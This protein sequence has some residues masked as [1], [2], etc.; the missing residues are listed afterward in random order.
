MSFSCR[1]SML[2]FA[3]FCTLPVEQ[4]KLAPPDSS[5]SATIDDLRK[6]LRAEDPKVR[7]QAAQKLAEFGP[8]AAAAVPDFFELIS[9]KFD[10]KYEEATIQTVLA[11]G[12]VGP[13]AFPYVVKVLETGR[14]DEVREMVNWLNH[15]YRPGSKELD[16]TLCKLLKQE[17]HA[18]GVAWL[19]HERGCIA[20]ALPTLLDHLE[21]RPANQN[22]GVMLALARFGPKAAPAIPYLVKVIR[23]SPKDSSERRTA[24]DALGAIAKDQKPIAN[25]LDRVLVDRGENVYVR[26]AAARGLGVS[27]FGNASVDALLSIV[28]TP[29][30]RNMTDAEADN[31]TGF[32]ADALE[33]AGLLG[34]EAKHVEPVLVG[35]LADVESRSLKTAALKTLAKMGPKAKS[36]A[37][38]LLASVNDNRFDRGHFDRD[39]FHALAQILGREESRAQLHAAT[40]PLLDRQR[41]RSINA[42]MAEYLSISE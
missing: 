28:T 33:A 41:G 40:Q 35:Y 14:P 31:W 34:L 12:A 2:V 15:N 11:L 42:G 1:L 30:D 29:P 27:Q 25:I 3:T 4:E 7:E 16:Q 38:T 22:G 10:P 23:E 39:Y 8:K 5:L 37:P 21:K 36:A 20:D 13:A 26:S 17:A 9:R 24:V 32:R 18:H 6:K 19:I